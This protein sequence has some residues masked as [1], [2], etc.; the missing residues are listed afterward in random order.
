MTEPEQPLTGGNAGGRVVRVGETVRKPWSAATPAVLELMAAVGDAGVDVPA[1]L[2]RDERGRQMLEYVP[3][4]LTLHTDPLAPA[5]L[6][7]VGGIVRAIHDACAGF[8]PR[9][10]PHWA[11]AIPAPGVELICHGDLAPWNLIIGERWVFID[12][13]GAGPSTRLWDL[14]YAAQAFTLNDP[15]ASASDSAAYLAAFVT[16]YGA[17]ASLRAALPCAMAARAGAMHEL[18]RSSHAAGVE[19]WASMYASGHGEHWAR[20]TRYVARHQEIWVSALSR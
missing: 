10:Q 15:A 4:T 19:P 14:A 6:G 7:R 16:G 18:L 1:F 9:A 3:G 5:E 11:S 13:D 2:G 17:D 20:A 12:W 8:V